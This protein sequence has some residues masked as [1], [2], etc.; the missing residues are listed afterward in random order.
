MD[1]LF[2]LERKDMRREIIIFE[3]GKIEADKVSEVKGN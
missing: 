2:R 3:L 1:R